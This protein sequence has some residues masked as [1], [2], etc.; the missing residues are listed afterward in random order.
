M[1]LDQM[2]NLL[3][4]TYTIGSTTNGIYDG[5][6][7]T[8][9]NQGLTQTATVDTY[10]Q[11]YYQ[12]IIYQQLYVQNPLYQTVLT[13][14]TCPGYVETAEDRARRARQKKRAEACDRAEELLLTCIGDGHKKSYKEHGYF[15]VEVKDRIFRI[16]KGRSM[17]ITEI[18]KGGIKIARWCVHPSEYVP[19]ADTMLAQ[20]LLLKTDERKFLE[21]ANRHRIAA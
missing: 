18:D 7:T 21:L 5:L 15:D 10:T 3:G 4:V 19:D 16:H 12:Q 11:H 6:Y 13:G 1:M 17:N 8:A 2:S 9:I 14:V 20:Y